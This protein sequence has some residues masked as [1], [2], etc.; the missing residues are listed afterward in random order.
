MFLLLVLHEEV[1][2]EEAVRSGDL[3]E[4]SEEV[5]GAYENAHASDVQRGHLLQWVVVS[6]VAIYKISEYEAIGK[7]LESERRSVLFITDEVQTNQ[8]LSVAFSMRLCSANKKAITE[9]LRDTYIIRLQIRRTSISVS[10]CQYTI[11]RY[12]TFA[13]IIS[14]TIIKLARPNQ[15]KMKRMSVRMCCVFSNINISPTE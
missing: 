2:Q 11:K 4:Q 1:A 8:S 10:K 15:L 9:I 3:L 14:G 13:I 7:K 6:F 5:L 12:T